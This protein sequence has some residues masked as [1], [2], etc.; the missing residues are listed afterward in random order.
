MIVTLTANP[1][2]D[3]RSNS[4]ERCEPGAVQR[5]TSTRQDPGGKGVNVTRALRASGVESVAVLPASP[6][7]R[8]S[9]RS[10]PRECPSVR[11]RSA[12]RCAPTSRSW[13]PRA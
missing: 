9:R 10:S 7:T 1:S 4:T 8:S 13:M 6:A 5:A 3:R 12:A 2:L 11:C